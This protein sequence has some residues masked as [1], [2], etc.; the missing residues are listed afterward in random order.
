MSLKQ[1]YQTHFANSGPKQFVD[2]TTESH[3]C[4]LMGTTS[5]GAAT[6]GYLF[7]KMA[8]QTG[9]ILATS[10]LGFIASYWTEKDGYAYTV[11]MMAAAIFLAGGVQLIQDGWT[12]VHSIALIFLNDINDC[13]YCG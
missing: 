7:F 1:I 8:P 5:I 2:N 10:G 13:D 4:L 9:A 3:L 12:I 6:I 11:G